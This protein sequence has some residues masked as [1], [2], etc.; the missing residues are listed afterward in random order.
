MNELEIHIKMTTKIDIKYTYC[1]KQIPSHVHILR[2]G[3]PFVTE[4][5]YLPNKIMCNICV[6]E[7]ENEDIRMKTPQKIEKLMDVNKKD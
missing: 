4:D 5:F 6:D 3:I 1:G 7:W 2:G